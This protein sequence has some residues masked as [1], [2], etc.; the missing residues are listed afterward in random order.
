MKNHPFTLAMPPNNIT[1]LVICTVLCICAGGGGMQASTPP[2]TKHKANIIAS[3]IAIGYLHT[4]TR[5]ACFSITSRAR[6]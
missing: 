4:D 2:H 1:I 3:R 5:E 6:G